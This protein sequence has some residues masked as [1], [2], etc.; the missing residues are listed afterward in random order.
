VRLLL[1]LLASVSW[2]QD[3]PFYIRNVK[4]DQS[5]GG[6]NQNFREAGIAPNNVRDATDQN[7]VNASLSNIACSPSQALLGQ[8]VSGGIATAGTCG[9]VAVLSATQTFS[10][11]NTFSSSV[12]VQGIVGLGPT[13]GTIDL[14][15]V[16]VYAKSVD[17]ISQS[18]GC[19]VVLNYSA[20]GSNG[21]LTFTSTTTAAVGSLHGVLMQSCAPGNV[22]AT[23]VMGIVRTV[24]SASL[25]A[26]NTLLTSTTRCQVTDTGTVSVTTGGK[27][28]NSCTAGGWSWAYLTGP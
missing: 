14:S 11:A 6:L 2:A 9:S 12:N 16:V 5:F 28:M 18:S 19:F 3:A 23:A 8:S 13:S 1:L 25:T 24:C 26:G 20:Q 10:G 22:C 7:D 15:P 21:I 27:L 4:D 17:G